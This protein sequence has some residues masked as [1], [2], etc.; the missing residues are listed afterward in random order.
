MPV[1]LV[2]MLFE[3]VLGKANRR[4]ARGCSRRTAQFQSLKPVQLRRETPQRQE[5]QEEEKSQARLQQ[6]RWR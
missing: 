5:A 3:R 6:H 4:A 1:S 2:S